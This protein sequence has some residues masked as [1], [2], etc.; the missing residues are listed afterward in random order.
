MA[1]I[2]VTHW[3]HPEVVARLAPIAS[4]ELNETRE[5]WPKAVLHRHLRDAEAVVVFMPDRVDA[6]FLDAAPRLRIVACALKG[7][8]NIDVAECRR[9]GV[10]VT[11]VE[12]LLT[13]PTA[14]LAIALLLALSRNV[15]RGDARVRAPGYAGWRPVLYG[16]ALQGRTVGIVGFGRLGRAV[17]KRI[18][19]F[20]ATVRFSDP[21]VTDDARAMALDDLLA[22]SHHVIL[23][24]PLTKAT[25]RLFDAQR[26]ARMRF[27]ATLVNVGRGSVVDEESVADALGMER[28][29]GY[30]A[31]V[32]EFEDLSLAD[33]PRTIPA[34]LLAL[35]DRTVFTPHLGS[36]VDDVRLAIAMQAAEAVADLFEGREPR[37]AVT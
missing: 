31:D 36:A 4:L 3:V 29:S 28:L 19:A 20:G 30:A 1:T 21:A 15:L 12:D 22:A 10:R 8:D 14:D 37:G 24:A 18:E 32:F 34:S 25:Y 6:E 27:G 23:A 11:I 5:S 17:A 26:L 33:R 35:S 2:V 7:Y 9:R 16:A 13:E